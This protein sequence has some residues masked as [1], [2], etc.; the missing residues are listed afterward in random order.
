MKARFLASLFVMAVFLQAAKETKTAQSYNNEGVKLLNSH[1]Y[2][3]A[4]V[5]F[6][7]AVELS[8]PNSRQQMTALGNL[9]VAY[10]ILGRLDEE[11]EVAA[12]ADKIWSYLRSSSGAPPPE[13]GPSA[14][15]HH[16]APPAKEP[17]SAPG[18]DGNRSTYIAGIRRKLRERYV[19]PKEGMTPPVVLLRLDNHGRILDS[20]I[21]IKSEPP[22]WGNSLL[23]A[24]KDAAPFELADGDVDRFVDLRIE[25]TASVK[26]RVAD[27]TETPQG[28]SH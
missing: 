13:T 6:E 20:D 16:L 3:K 14:I 5:A 24:I 19:P 10:H 22:V 11:T 12:K 15:G 7:K 25:G 18:S 26:I 4:V 27:P 28:W 17:L 2:E 23:Q 1:A 8:E 21:S 9:S